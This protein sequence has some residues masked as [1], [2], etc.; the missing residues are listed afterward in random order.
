MEDMPNPRE[1]PVIH[2]QKGF[3]GEPVSQR[4]K[5]R[6]TR[7]LV[8]WKLFPDSEISPAK[9]EQKE[10]MQQFAQEMSEW[11][12]LRTG[13]DVSKK[14]R[15]ASEKTQFYTEDE[16]KQLQAV[17]PALQEQKQDGGYVSFTNEIAVELT[18]TPAAIDHRIIHELVHAASHSAVFIVADP[19][20]QQ[21]MFLDNTRGLSGYKNL[22]TNAFY[23]FD[24]SITELMTIEFEIWRQYKATKG[25]NIPRILYDTGVIFFD[26]AIENAAKRVGKTPEEMRTAIYAGY[27]SGD[28]TQLQVLTQAFGKDALKT[29]SSMTSYI[30]DPIELA[31]HASLFAIDPHAYLHKVEEYRNGN[32]IHVLGTM[33][34][35][36]KS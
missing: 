23:L 1:L 26:M 16:W 35:D 15:Q 12:V 32:P 30:T 34:I 21:S 18:G 9:Q 31:K 22:A 2:L 10:L 29:I 3:A 11:I 13:Y 5:D 27:L 6:V 17:L 7:E 25:Q 33:L 19:E 36:N 4:V 8:T 20:D 14:I 28:S 24:E